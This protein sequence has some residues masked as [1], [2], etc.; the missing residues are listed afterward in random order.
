MKIP[1]CPPLAKGG[2]GDLEVI[3]YVTIMPL[4]TLANHEKYECFQC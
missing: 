3:F 1:P 2:W 4:G